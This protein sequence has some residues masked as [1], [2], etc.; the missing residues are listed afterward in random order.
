MFSWLTDL[1]LNQA[2]SMTPMMSPSCI[3]R[4]SSPSPSRSAGVLAEQHPVA[5]LDIDRNQFAVIVFLALP[6][7]EDFALLGF[8]RRCRE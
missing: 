7:G 3:T 1:V 4:S 2:P 6:H 5:D 8:S